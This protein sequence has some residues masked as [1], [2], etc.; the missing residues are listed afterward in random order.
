MPPRILTLH[1]HAHRREMMQHRFWIYNLSLFWRKLT[2]SRFQKHDVKW[3]HSKG[4]WCGS[5]FRAMKWHNL[6]ERWC[7]LD[8]QGTRRCPQEISDTK[9]A[10]ETWEDVHR[11]QAMLCGLHSLKIYFTPQLR[12]NL[13]LSSFQGKLSNVNSLQS[14]F[15][16]TTTFNHHSV[17]NW[18]ILSD[19]LPIRGF[20]KACWRPTGKLFKLEWQFLFMWLNL[21][22]S[23]KLPM[24]PKEES[25][26][27]VI[28]NFFF[29][30]F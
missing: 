4:R 15:S 12:T 3:H 11:R 2:L 8:L 21:V 6:E 1:E 26:H 10:S 24:Y 17:S 7:R 30:F 23:T 13:C 19:T 18:L 29:F 5:N 28:Q 27:H 20:L 25:S 9:H 14:S 22:K 16:T